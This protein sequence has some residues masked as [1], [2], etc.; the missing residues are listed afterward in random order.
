[1]AQILG[2]LNTCQ[3]VL[4]GTP[5]APGTTKLGK[6]QQAGIFPLS[7]WQLFQLS[8]WRFPGFFTDLGSWTACSS[9]LVGAVMGHRR[10]QHF[11]AVWGCSDQAFYQGVGTKG[12]SSS[13]LEI[14]AITASMCIDHKL[15]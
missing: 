11:R 13:S 5:H 6:A 8:S 3:G 9:Q 1:M 15:L 12:G 14:R 7:A 2:L 4:R 10:N